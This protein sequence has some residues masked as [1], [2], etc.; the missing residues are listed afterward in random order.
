MG[1]WV[2]VWMIG[3]MEG[4]RAICVREWVYGNMDCW[5]IDEWVDGGIDRGWME[6]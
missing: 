6:G 3:W 5:V 2:N 1:G 4:G